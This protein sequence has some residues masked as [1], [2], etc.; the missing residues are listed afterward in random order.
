MCRRLPFRSLPAF[1]FVS[2]T[3][4]EARAGWGIPMATDIAFA[5]GVLALLGDRIPAGAKLLLLSVAI[6]DDIIAITVIALFYAESVSM[7]WLAGAV[8]GLAVVVVM[9]RLGVNAIWPYAMV[10]VV[11]WV[12]TLE[13]GV[14]ATIAGVPLGLLTP[15]RDV[16]GRNVLATLAP[17][18][19]H[20]PAFE[21]FPP[22]VIGR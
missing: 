12:A 4:G 11:V 7:S 20:C 14:H 15:A 19:P 10:G 1:I 16:G 5:V 8:V 9:R 22:F 21:V 6:V 2:L 13:S 18:L 3:S 17:R